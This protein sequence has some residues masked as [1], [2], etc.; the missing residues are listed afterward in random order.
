MMNKLKIAH[1]IAGFL[2]A[3]GLTI[4]FVIIGAPLA[5]AVWG[6]LTGMYLMGWLLS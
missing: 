3:L 1:K 4:M 5:A 2:S 6:F